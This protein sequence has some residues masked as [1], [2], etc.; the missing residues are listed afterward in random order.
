MQLERI[1]YSRYQKLLRSHDRED[2]NEKA[3]TLLMWNSTS[4]FVK[5]LIRELESYFF[6]RSSFSLAKSKLLCLGSKISSISTSFEAFYERVLERCP[7]TTNK[8]ASERSKPH[9][10]SSLDSRII[11]IHI[12]PFSTP[13][14]C[15]RKHKVRCGEDLHGHGCPIVSNG[16]V[17][18]PCIKLE[19]CSVMHTIIYTRMQNDSKL[20]DHLKRRYVCTYA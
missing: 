11:L 5:Q 14:D 18:S 19:N 15:R 2:W 4:C 8:R 9:I 12:L 10:H 20:P 16:A 3:H 1:Q 7:V 17:V 13:T 6:R